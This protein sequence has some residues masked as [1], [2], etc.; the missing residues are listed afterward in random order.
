MYGLIII[1]LNYMVQYIIFFYFCIDFKHRI[2]IF[3]SIDYNNK[4]IN[5]D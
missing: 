4:Y 2:G 3:Q 5:F 1:N